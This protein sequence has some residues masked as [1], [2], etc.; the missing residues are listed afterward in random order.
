MKDYQASYLLQNLKLHSHSACCN[1]AAKLLF[2]FPTFRE[3]FI[4]LSPDFLLQ[5]LRKND[6]NAINIHKNFYEKHFKM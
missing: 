6:L 4:K 1:I 5:C 2:I 3:G